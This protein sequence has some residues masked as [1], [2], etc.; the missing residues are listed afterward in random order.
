MR[1]AS[2]GR[3][4]DMPADSL[5]QE[6]LLEDLQDSS[7][8]GRTRRGR[9]VKG[10]SGNPA[11]RAA[12]SRNHATVIAEQLLDC[13]VRSLTRKALEM[14]LN[15]DAAALRLCLDRIIGPRRERPIRFA[16]PPIDS[17]AD[18]HAAMAAITAAVGRGDITAGEAY[19]LSQVVD[20]FVR[21]IDAS[22][23]E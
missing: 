5:L 14:A 12:G 9:F 20:T 18:L 16:L 19:E 2:I 17:A 6:G 21:A 11:G 8:L 15:G 7:K 13:E 1:I 10:L 22:D 3:R 4:M 23:F